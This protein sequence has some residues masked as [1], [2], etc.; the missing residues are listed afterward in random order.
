[1]NEREKKKKS[2]AIKDAFKV[3]NY[4]FAAI[5]ISACSREIV[6]PVS[7]R[8]PTAEAVLRI[9]ELDSRDYEID[10]N[11][12]NIPE[13][14][15]V[16]PSEFIYVVWMVT[17]EDGTINIGPLSVGQDNQGSLQYSSAYQPV[18]IFVTEEANREVVLP[19]SIIVLDSKEFEL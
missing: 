17:R 8:M 9:D 1:M 3:L 12:Y 2:L 19:S 6:F 5:L 18:R 13:A 7:D 10:L 11:V 4:I 16:I 15:R 14:K